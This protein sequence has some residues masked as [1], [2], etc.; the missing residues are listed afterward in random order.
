MTSKVSR[1]IIIYDRLLV[2][3]RQSG[4]ACSQP[5]LPAT[6]TFSTQGTFLSEI[7]FR[8]GCVLNVRWLLCALIRAY[9]TTFAS[10]T[11]CWNW[12]RKVWVNTSRQNA[13]LFRGSTSCQMTNFSRSC[14]RRRTRPPCSHISGNA[15]RTSPR[16]GD[17]LSPASAVWGFTLISLCRHHFVDM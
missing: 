2:S 7:K 14:H 9:W 12:Y 15:L 13:T 1:L 5:V 4:M 16:F 8:V 10:A 3:I 11:S 17:V 6:Y